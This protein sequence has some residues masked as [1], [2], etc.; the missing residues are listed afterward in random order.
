MEKLIASGKCCFQLAEWVSVNV[1]QRYVKVDELRLIEGFRHR[2]ISLTDYLRKTSVV[3]GMRT[4]HQTQ[5]GKFSV[6]HS[7]TP[8]PDANSHGSF[9]REEAVEIH[10]QLTGPWHY[11]DDI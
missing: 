10:F 3:A 4:E 11:Q 8:G 2:N 6:L 5:A 7:R 9:I 1:T